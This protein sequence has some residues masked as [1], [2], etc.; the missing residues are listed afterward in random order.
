MSVLDEFLDMGEGYGIKYEHAATPPSILAI[1]APWRGSRESAKVS[2]AIVALKVGWVSV[3]TPL[4]TRSVISQSRPTK[5][6][7]VMSAIGWRVQRVIA[8][9]FVMVLSV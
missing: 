1:F 5:L 8:T 7:T 6:P 2:N 3:S 4:R 9:Q